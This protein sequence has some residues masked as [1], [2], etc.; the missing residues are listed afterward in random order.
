MSHVSPPQLGCSCFSLSRRQLLRGVAGA[1]GAGLALASMAR[2]GSAKAI[3]LTCMDYRL[4]DDAVKYLHGRGLENQYDHVVLAGASAG[5]LGKL[6]PEWASTFWKHVDT[7]I[8]LHHVSELIVIDH[9][10]CGAFKIV[11]GPDSIADRTRETN[12]HRGLLRELRDQTNAKFPTLGTQILLMDLNG[13]VED[14]SG[15]D[16]LDP[17]RQSPVAK[18]EEPH[19]AAHGPEPTAAHGH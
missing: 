17:Y 4:V 15:L 10:D 12:L 7:A 8:K 3:V 2:A 9:R 1:A 18:A 14:L 19:A 13:G 11:Y 16:R 6:G 5:A